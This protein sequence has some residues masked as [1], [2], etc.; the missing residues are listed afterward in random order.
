MFQKLQQNHLW[1]QTAIR[2]Q[3]TGVPN[4]TAQHCVPNETAW[5]F[6]W[7]HCPVIKTEIAQ[8]PLGERTRRNKEDPDHFWSCVT[9]MEFVRFLCQCGAR[10]QFPRPIIYEWIWTFFFFF[11]GVCHLPVRHGPSGQSWR[12]A[13][14]CALG[15]PA[16]LLA[17]PS[18]LRLGGGGR[19]ASLAAY[20]ARFRC[21]YIGLPYCCCCAKRGPETSLTG[22]SFSHPLAPL[23]TRALLNVM[24]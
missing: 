10:L 14:S 4:E 11:T 23:L 20:R 22:L 2:K 7:C 6:G 8:T 5:S 16:V 9:P 18:N 12:G 21:D 13:S 3:D 1:K 15:D 19:R 17:S 24:R